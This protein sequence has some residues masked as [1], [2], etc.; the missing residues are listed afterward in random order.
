MIE[1]TDKKLGKMKVLNVT[2]A[3]ANFASVLND[4]RN[5]YIITKNNKPVRVMIDYA[6]YEKL[7]AEAARA[8]SVD[9]SIVVGEEDLGQDSASKKLLKKKS[10][11]RVPGILKSHMELSGAQNKADELEE[12]PLSEDPFDFEEQGSQQAQAMV[13][14]SAPQSLTEDDDFDDLLGEEALDDFEQD[15]EEAEEQVF[16]EQPS[17]S[18]AAEQEEILVEA[19]EEKSPEQEAYFQK[20]RKLY[21]ASAQKQETNVPVTATQVEE[22]TVRTPV[23]E[24]AKPKSQDMA[25]APQKTPSAPVAKTQ[26]AEANYFQEPEEENTSSQSVNEI[27]GD[28]N[29][30]KSKQEQAKKS[31]MEDDD[32]PS[33]KDLL[34]DLEREK[35]S[36]EGDDL[37]TS[38]IDEIIDQLTDSY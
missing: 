2:E 34:M 7:T 24:Q 25:P 19:T 18:S 36:G 38:E 28:D 3:R 17:P 14:E 12:A 35:L 33:L 5:H 11:S 26:A 27:R 6:D 15:F 22:P 32:L 37:E 30:I 16:S 13:P 23:V 20:Y 4:H 21:E 1:Y 8:A 29:F 9:D 31:V 10:K